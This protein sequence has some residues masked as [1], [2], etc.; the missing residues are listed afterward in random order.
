MAGSLG[1]NAALCVGR[2]SGIGVK[3]P[4]EVIIATGVGVYNCQSYT[5]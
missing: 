1:R 5:T 2:K 3:L 4:K